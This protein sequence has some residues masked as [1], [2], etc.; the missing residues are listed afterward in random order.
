[1]MPEFDDRDWK[2]GPGGFGTRGTPGAIV[3]TEWN[4]PD[5][6][7]RREIDVAADGVEPIRATR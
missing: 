7:L 2:Q 5:I 3:R 4:G 6:W 1:M